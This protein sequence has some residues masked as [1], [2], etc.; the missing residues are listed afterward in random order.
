MES[1]IRPHIEVFCGAITFGAQSR[2]K[3]NFA[4]PPCLGPY[5]T[6]GRVKRA[7][8]QH[9]VFLIADALCVFEVRG[10]SPEFVSFPIHG[11]RLRPSAR[12]GPDFAG[13]VFEISVKLGLTPDRSRQI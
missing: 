11:N 5:D 9:S 1:C 10:G 12:S 4:I 3:H 8:L 6:G 13:Q 7:T 2:T